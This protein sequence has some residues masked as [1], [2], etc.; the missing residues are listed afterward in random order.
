[1][2]VGAAESSAYDKVGR[3]HDRGIENTAIVQLWRGV[4]DLIPQILDR[5]TLE[6]GWRCP[7]RRRDTACAA[8]KLEDGSG[9]GVGRAGGSWTLSFASG[10]R[11]KLGLELL[12]CLE[13]PP[14]RHL[15]SRVSP[16]K[17]ELMVVVEDMIRGHRAVCRGSSAPGVVYTAAQ[18]YLGR[19]VFATCQRHQD[20]QHQ[21]QATLSGQSHICVTRHD[22]AVPLV[23]TERMPGEPSITRVKPKSPSAWRHLLGKAKKERGRRGESKRGQGRPGKAKGVEWIE[24]EVFDSGGPRAPL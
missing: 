19:L 13:P 14:E 9:V 10:L 2:D 8:R 1:M 6:G 18:R 20:E 21:E 12:L 7:V 16:R 17:V 22:A 24:L 3:S 4:L 15:E 11:A 23:L 5:E